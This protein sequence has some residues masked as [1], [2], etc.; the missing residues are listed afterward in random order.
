MAIKLLHKAASGGLPFAQFVLGNHYSKGNWVELDLKQ[1]AH[2]WQLAAQQG[3]ARAAHN[4][5]V[6]YRRG[7]VFERDPQQALYWLR[8]AA[9]GGSELSTEMVQ[10]LEAE[11]ALQQGLAALEKPK[12]RDVTSATAP[13][14]KW[15]ADWLKG[16]EPKSFLLQLFASASKRNA[17]RLLAELKLGTLKQRRSAVIYPVWSN[18]K[19]VWAVGYGEFASRAEALQAIGQLPAKLKQLRP[20]PRKIEDI[21]RMQPLV[22]RFLELSGAPQATELET[23]SSKAQ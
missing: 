21:Q 6:L 22:G 9:Q 8:R 1:A 17:Q 3:S 12:A 15:F 11:L 5:G 16:R 18:Q 19:V 23:T 2:W 10:E 13:Q 4:L 14:G 7:Y 20:W